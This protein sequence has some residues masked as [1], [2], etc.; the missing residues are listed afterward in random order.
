METTIIKE[1]TAEKLK[2]YA[3]KRLGSL[4]A[5]LNSDDIIVWLLNRGEVQN[6]SLAT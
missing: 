3:W 4:S 5:G 6:E 1:S 2:A